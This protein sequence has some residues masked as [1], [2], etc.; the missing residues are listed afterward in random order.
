MIK[1]LGLLMVLVVAGV[2][3]PSQSLA[4]CSVCSD[5]DLVEMGTDA[6]EANG[7]EDQ[8]YFYS[9]ERSTY[10]GN[11]F[12][13]KE[14]VKV[15]VRTPCSGAIIR[16]VQILDH[17]KSVVAEYELGRTG[18]HDYVYSAAFNAPQ[19]PGLYYLDINLKVFLNL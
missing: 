4:Q 8:V 17:G 6:L 12:S 19:P 2:V 18:S 1:E 9:Q 14:A 15:A 11:H 10:T 3:F 13:T 16:Q 7:E 5:N